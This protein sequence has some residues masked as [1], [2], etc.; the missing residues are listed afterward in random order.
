MDQFLCLLN[1]FPGMYCHKLWSVSYPHT[2][3]TKYKN[4]KLVKNLWKCSGDK[5]LL[6]RRQFYAMLDIWLYFL[7]AKR[8]RK[9]KNCKTVYF[10]VEN[11]LIQLN[12]YFHASNLRKT[13]ITAKI[14]KKYLEHMLGIE[15]NW[16]AKM[17]CK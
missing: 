2:C 16:K 3:A 4:R 5:N 9:L 17:L 14:R 8:H 7:A 13:K 1:E 11:K 10:D 12:F 6:C 15:T